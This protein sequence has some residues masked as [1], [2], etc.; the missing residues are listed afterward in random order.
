MMRQLDG[1]G[2]EWPQVESGSRLGQR[3]LRIQPRS[4]LP[5]RPSF[6]ELPAKVWPRSFP[7]YASSPWTLGCG[8]EIPRHLSMPGDLSKGVRK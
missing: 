8:Q 4:E 3:I 7:L 1:P 6:P 5:E 2:N